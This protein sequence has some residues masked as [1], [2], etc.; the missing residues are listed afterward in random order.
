[1]KY[2]TNLDTPYSY[3]LMDVD[4]TVHAACGSISKCLSLMASIWRFE[5]VARK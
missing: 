2:S 1:M 5:V 4:R 3:L